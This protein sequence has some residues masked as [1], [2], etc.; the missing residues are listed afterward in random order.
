VD[1]L[2]IRSERAATQANLRGPEVITA[3]ALAPLDRLL[4]LAA[5]LFMPGTV[6]VFLKGRDAAAELA[7]AAKMWI[8]KVDMVAS[9]TE[10]DGC[11]LMIRQLAPRARAGSQ[12]RRDK[13]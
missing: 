7:A 12:G 10:P 3:R 2:S 13:G 9:R 11:I 8:F 1:I 6:G 4:G 5:P